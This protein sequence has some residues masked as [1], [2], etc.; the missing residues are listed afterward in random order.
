MASNARP[1]FKPKVP[2]RKNN[3]DDAWYRTGSYDSSYMFNSPLPPDDE[4]DM[5]RYRQNPSEYEYVKRIRGEQA[6]HRISSETNPT[7]KNYTQSAD[8]PVDTS[9]HYISSD[10]SGISRHYAKSVNSG[11]FSRNHVPSDASGISKHYSRSVT[12][13][14][15]GISKHY[16]QVEILSG[17]YPYN[18]Q[19]QREIPNGTP[20]EI[21][22]I[23][24]N[25]DRSPSEISGI[26]K[27]YAHSELSGISKDYAPSEA[28][29][30]SGIN[31]R[32][33]ASGISKHYD[34]FSEAGKS[35][36]DI[37]RFYD[38]VDTS[39]GK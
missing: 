29:G 5:I 28:S 15:S 32:S 10:S 36:G 1:Q 20:Q 3:N 23:P 30:I 35:D 12:S 31:A 22:R 21:I 34:N 6:Q 7:S 27:H 2:F 9:Q 11:E 14:A 39:P 26:S 19:N 4:D 8:E 24:R 13:D 17:P 38:E 18:P 25:F 16:Q 37:S 33:E